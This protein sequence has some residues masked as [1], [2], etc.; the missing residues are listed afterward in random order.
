[1]PRIPRQYAQ[2]KPAVIP[3]VRVS[4]EAMTQDIRAM[5]QFG[6]TLSQV[7]N[8]FQT[9][10][11]VA[12]E[13]SEFSNA[14]NTWK[15]GV[16]QFK[17]GL[18]TDYRTHLEQFEKSQVDLYKQVSSNITEPNAQTAFKRFADNDQVDERF[19]IGREA[20]KLEIN[21]MEADYYKQ[22]ELAIKRGDIDFINKSTAGAVA[23]GY[24][25]AD[26]GEKARES[27]IKKVEY[28]STWQTAISFQDE[29]SAMEFVEQTKGLS[30]GE[31]N[32]LLAAVS[33]HFTAGDARQKE[34]VET[35]REQERKTLLPKM[36]DRSLSP[37][38]I[39][40]SSFDEKEKKQWF[41]WMDSRNKA[42]ASGKV[43]PLTET[44]DSVYGNMS[45][46]INLYPET[47]KK[48]DIWE[49]HGKGLSTD[50]CEKLTKQHESNLKDPVKFQAGKRAHRS[51]LKL[52]SSG[53]F[54][55]D[56]EAEQIWGQKANALDNYLR[57][58]PDAS[59][60]EITKYFEGLV[61]EEK[62][63]F[64][65]QL[66]DAFWNQLTFGLGDKIKGMV[67]EGTA[68]KIIGHKDGKPVY[69]LPDGKWQVG[70]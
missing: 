70:E 31:R 65:G 16:N 12:R 1:M 24:L 47:V 49:L 38:D 55:E 69:E 59:N 15:E 32:S 40:N 9:K 62:S 33:R 61:A 39:Y 29:E 8:E 7:G 2:T 27:A 23:G 30:P 5:G 50:D 36:R 37:E 60:E 6:E 48:S 26:V 10:M 13:A 64:F 58:N 57:D 66:L 11:R 54:G 46:R 41:G 52:K 19:K 14:K 45:E 28:E 63:N 17:L 21:A 20:R 4:P 25:K 44:N 56:V 22:I 18:G 43:D 42:I 53:V 34:A 3:G 51:L 68:K 67:E 35:Q